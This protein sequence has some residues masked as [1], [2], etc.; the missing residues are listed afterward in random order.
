MEYVCNLNP[1]QVANS[2][3]LEGGDEFSQQG[4]S[5]FRNATVFAIYHKMD[6]IHLQK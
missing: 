2:L 4:V 1:F 3:S 5:N 6:D